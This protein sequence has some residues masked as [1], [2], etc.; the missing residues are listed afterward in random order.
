MHFTAAL[1]GATRICFGTARPPGGRR[2]AL[3]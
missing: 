2:R 3:A 1:E